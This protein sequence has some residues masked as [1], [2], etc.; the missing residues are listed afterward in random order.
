VRTRSRYRFPAAAG[1]IALIELDGE[2][3]GIE[4]ALLRLGE[5]C[6]RAGAIDV[7]VAQDA[8]ERRSMW[9]ARRAISPALRDAHRRKIGEDICVPRGRIGEMLARIDALAADSGLAVATFGHAGDGNLHVNLLVDEDPDLPAVAARVARALDGLFRATVAL[10]GTLSGEHGI[11][12]AKRDYLP[13]EQPPRVIEWQ[14]R[15]KA[16]WDP[17]DLLNPGK[18][19]PPV[20]APGRPEPL[21]PR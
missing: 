4:P 13:L 1:A 10:G 3:E 16:M 14:R 2:P 9:E 20:D 17:D 7:L 19:L 15:W 18:V 11:G 8:S 6:E 21:P 5:L 12:L